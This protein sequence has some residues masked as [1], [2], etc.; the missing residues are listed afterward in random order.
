MRS[1]LLVIHYLVGVRAL[2]WHG[3]A[4]QSSPRIGLPINLSALCEVIG[5][6]QKPGETLAARPALAYLYLSVKHCV[7]V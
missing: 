7:P 2:H 6:K 4:G 1:A 5:E 3:L